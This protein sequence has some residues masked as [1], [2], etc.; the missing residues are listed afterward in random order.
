VNEAEFLRDTTGNRRFWVV[1]VLCEKIDIELLKTERDGI[2]ASAVDAYLSE[3]K[4][5]LSREEEKELFKQNQKYE[6]TDALLEKIDNYVGMRPEI[7]AIEIMERLL[8]I[9][10]DEYS[11]HQT[12]VGICLRK[13]GFEKQKPVRTPEGNRTFWRRA[14][15]E[16]ALK[17]LLVDDSTSLEETSETID[18]TIDK[19]YTE[20]I[21]SPKSLE[22]E[23]SSD[24]HIVDIV[25]T[26]IQQ[27][28]SFSL[29]KDW[30]DYTNQILPEGTVIEFVD[31]KTKVTFIGKV[32]QFDNKRRKA[33]ALVGEKELEISQKE[34]KAY[35]G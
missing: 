9:G 8:E 4:H 3:E 13:L 16:E 26:P 20:T 6:L 21:C 32:L 19:L 11:K 17:G 33:R 7:S 18:T 34:I 31:Q 10:V 24:T 30:I 14:I 35:I 23:D 29:S 15:D 25:K 12:K 5:Y 2:W 27:P 22:N 28:I 1:E